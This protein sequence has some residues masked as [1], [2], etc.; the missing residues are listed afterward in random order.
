MRMHHKQIDFLL[1]VRVVKKD[2]FTNQIDQV[3]ICFFKRNR[4]IDYKSSF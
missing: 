3:S 4:V 2:R 1:V